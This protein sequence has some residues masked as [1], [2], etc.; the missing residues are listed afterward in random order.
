MG[1]N[2]LELR[3]YGLLVTL[4]DRLIDCAHLPDIENNCRVN[5]QID[6]VLSES[7]DSLLFFVAPNVGLGLVLVFGLLL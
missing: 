2:F 5:Y 1:I 6:E 3:L 7:T 4:N